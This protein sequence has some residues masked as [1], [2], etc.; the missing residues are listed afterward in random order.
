MAML[1]EVG[2]PRI[3]LAAA[4]LRDRARASLTWRRRKSD[5]EGAMAHA[6]TPNPE[7]GHHKHQ[8]PVETRSKSAF[9]DPRCWAG[10]V[11]LTGLILLLLQ[12][13]AEICF[14]DRLI[15]ALIA[16]DKL[17]D[18]R[19]INFSSAFIGLWVLLIG[20]VLMILAQLIIS[21]PSK[22]AQGE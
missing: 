14:D 17:A 22:P 6:P 8:T 18:A 19:L 11:I 21:W 20:A 7:G 5:T 1:L 12:L 2:A 3:V 16:K 15:K 10:G 13:A 4:S 9:C